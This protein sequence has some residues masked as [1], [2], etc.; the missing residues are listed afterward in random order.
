M[1]CNVDLFFNSNKYTKFLFIS[2]DLYFIYC[3]DQT[4]AEGI[5]A[6]YLKAEENFGKKIIIITVKPS[7]IFIWKLVFRTEQ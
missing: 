5:C 4:S 2:N 1:T 7:R 3:R 6:H